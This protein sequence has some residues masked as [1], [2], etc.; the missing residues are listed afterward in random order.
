[1]RNVSVNSAPIPD[2]YASEHKAAAV[3]SLAAAL[4]FTLADLRRLDPGAADA[5]R[6]RVLDRL[7]PDRSTLSCP[8]G[9]AP[10]PDTPDD[11]AGVWIVRVPE[12]AR[13]AMRDIGGGYAMLDGRAGR[14]RGV[15]MYMNR[16]GRDRITLNGEFTAA[17]LRDLAAMM[18]PL[19]LAGRVRPMSVEE[20]AEFE[21][22]WQAAPSGPLVIVPDD[23]R[24]ALGR[25]VIEAAREIA[26][27]WDEAGTRDLAPGITGW[28]KADEA[29]ERLVQAVRA[30]E[31]AGAE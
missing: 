7:D 19:V 5:E 4:A 27:A 1:M 30:H 15:V 8:P 29:A 2:G 18:D 26:G 12:W 16:W 11:P 3:R 20:H 6:R 14:N 10:M 24:D 9:G 28:S 23:P 13:E 22:L 17:E 25:A 31:A 21:R